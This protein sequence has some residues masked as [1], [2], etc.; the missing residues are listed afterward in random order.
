M[1]S[2]ERCNSQNVKGVSLHFVNKMDKAT[3]LH[4]FKILE[5]ESM[6]MVKALSMT[7]EMPSL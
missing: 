6:A 2:K 1:N 7:L 4:C 3:Q 5:R